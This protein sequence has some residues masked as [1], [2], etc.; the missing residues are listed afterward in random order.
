MKKVFRFSRKMSLKNLGKFLTYLDASDQAIDGLHLDFKNDCLKLEVAAEAEGLIKAYFTE[1][2]SFKLFCDGGSRGNPGPGACGFVL[3]EGDK[4]LTDGG[5]FFKHCTNNQAEYQSLKQGLKAA[6]KR[7][8]NNLQIYMDSQLIVKQIKGEYKVRHSSLQ[9]LHQE[10]KA[11][12][13]KLKHY[14][15]NFV[16]RHFNQEADAVVNRILDEHL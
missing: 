13:A 5:Q 15:I 10:I 16:P 9:P 14:Q 6:L 12:L 2:N 11:D 1:K 4:L 7:Q 3:Y 8:I